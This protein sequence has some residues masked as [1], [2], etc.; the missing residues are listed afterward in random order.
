M[1]ISGSNRVNR[2]G[3]WNNNAKNCRSAN[4]NNNSPENRNNNL[5]FRV[6]SVQCRKVGKYIVQD[7]FLFVGNNSATNPYKP[8]ILVATVKNYVAF[9]RYFLGCFFSTFKSYKR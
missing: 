2:G 4:R 7:I 9:L 8:C 5:G 6:C 1:S 3:S